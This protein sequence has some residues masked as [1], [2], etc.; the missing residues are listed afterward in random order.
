LIH[1][2][3]SVYLVA[4]VKTVSSQ[5]VTKI[6]ERMALAAQ[7]TTGKDAP[8]KQG[9]R[10]DLVDSTKLNQSARAEQNGVSRFTQKR[11]DRLARD[12]TALHEEV[13]AGHLSV[14]RASIQAGFIRLCSV[15]TKLGRGT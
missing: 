13:K 1:I 15:T 12:F 14:H 2:A 5:G 11:L 9:E 3:G 10:I 7:Q 4:S 8:T 6:T